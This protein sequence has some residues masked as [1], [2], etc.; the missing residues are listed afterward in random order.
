[1]ILLN[2]ILWGLAVTLLIAIAS[3]CIVSTIQ[4]PPRD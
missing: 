3:L 1:M 4:G 2:A